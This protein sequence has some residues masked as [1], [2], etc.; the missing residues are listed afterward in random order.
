MDMGIVN[1]GQLPVIEDLNPDLRQAVEDVLF[2][3]HRR[4]R[5]A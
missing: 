4:P 1:A 3:R 2:N 5:S